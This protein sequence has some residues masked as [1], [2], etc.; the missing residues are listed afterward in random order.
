MVHTIAR[1]IYLN[2]YKITLNKPKLNKYIYLSIYLSIHISWMEL[3]LAYAFPPRSQ[4]M[5]STTHR[6]ECQWSWVSFFGFENLFVSCRSIPE[7]IFVWK[8]K[9]ANALLGDPGTTVRL[10]LVRAGES[11]IVY[12]VVD[13]NVCMIV[14]TFVRARMLYVCMY[15]CMCIYT[16][17]RQTV[18]G[19]ILQRALTVFERRGFS[20]GFRSMAWPIAYLDTYVWGWAD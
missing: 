1:Q 18:L 12:Q 17:M 13:S 2:C 15:V 20:L 19:H 14:Y 16:Y 11:G 6:W 5:A 3:R 9:T 10:G 7:A 8:Q 4:T